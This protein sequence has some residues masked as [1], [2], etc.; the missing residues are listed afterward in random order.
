MVVKTTN[1]AANRP[2][3]IRKKVEIWVAR[4]VASA[5]RN[6]APAKPTNSELSDCDPMMKRAAVMAST[7]PARKGISDGPRLLSEAGV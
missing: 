4:Q 5:A 2:A 1:S 7:A 3:K 6:P